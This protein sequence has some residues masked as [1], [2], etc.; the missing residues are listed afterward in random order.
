MA[1]DH[2]LVLSY[3]SLGPNPCFYFV[4]AQKEIAK[5]L[6]FVEITG[7]IALTANFCCLSFVVCMA[8]FL[9]I[10][11]IHLPS[12]EVCI[13]MIRKKWAELSTAGQ[14]DFDNNRNGVP[15]RLTVGDAIKSLVDLEL[16]LLLSAKEGRCSLSKRQKLMNMYEVLGIGKGSNHAEQLVRSIESQSK[17][18]SPI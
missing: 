14:F 13:G 16:D 15:L 1:T 2:T 12:N 7:L 17:S 10:T 6:T 18:L 4:S 9:K 5:P 3:R 8:S 11:E